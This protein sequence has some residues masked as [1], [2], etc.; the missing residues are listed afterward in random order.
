MPT[1]TVAVAVRICAD[2]F[3]PLCLDC[4][5]ALGGKRYTLR[6]RQHGRQ[7]PSCVEM[8]RARDAEQFRAEIDAAAMER[9]GECGHAAHRHCELECYDLSSSP[10]SCP[11]SGFVP[12][13]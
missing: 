6:K 13:W 10:T 11:C 3:T 8:E 12:V 5:A 4:A 2:E 7:C 1:P 9:C